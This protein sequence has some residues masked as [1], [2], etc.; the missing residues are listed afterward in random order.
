MQQNNSSN[1][2]N[3]LFEYNDRIASEKILSVLKYLNIIIPVL[4]L[5]VLVKSFDATYLDCLIASAFVVCIM[6]K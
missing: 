1:S 6:R 2:N 3:E 5:G 4:F